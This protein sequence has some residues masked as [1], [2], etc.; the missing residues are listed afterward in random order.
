MTFY[1]C[2][3]LM[4]VSWLHAPYAYLVYVSE[5]HLSGKSSSIALP[6]TYL[7][8]YNLVIS[9]FDFSRVGYCF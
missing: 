5:L 8:I 1:C 3:L 4:S 6:Y 2:L 7:S 9:Y